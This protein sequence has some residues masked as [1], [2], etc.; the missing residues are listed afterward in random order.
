MALQCTETALETLELSDVNLGSLN[1]LPKSQARHRAECEVWWRRAEGLWVCHHDQEA[2]KA[3]Q[4]AL[5]VE[6]WHLDVRLTARKWEVE[7]REQGAFKRMKRMRSSR[8]P[9]NASTK[10]SSRPTSRNRWS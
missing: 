6:P 4:R 9:S 1:N 8:R 2:F 10:S 5:K 7:A 3:L